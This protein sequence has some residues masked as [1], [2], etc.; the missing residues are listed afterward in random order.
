MKCFSLLICLLVFSTSF[1]RQNA[2]ITTPNTLNEQYK[3][4]S[5]D[6]EIV[7]GFRVMKLY[8]MDQ[9]WKFVQDSVHKKQLTIANMNTIASQQKSEINQLKALLATSETEKADLISK[10]EN[11][12]VFGKLYTKSGFT[13][14][15]F[16]LLG[17]L[18]ALLVVVALMY[19]VT[20][21]STRELRNFNEAIYHEFEEYKHQA[22]EK[23]IKLSRELQNYRNQMADLKR[24]A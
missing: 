13:T 20:F 16:S 21:F 12:A 9:F 23:Q 7:D 4:L 1:A 5:A 18:V 11:I 14:F 3:A 15:V 8:K 17:G 19:R 10:V 22:V 6:C 24:S 2:E